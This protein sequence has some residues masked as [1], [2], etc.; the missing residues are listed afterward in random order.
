MSNQYP[1]NKDEFLEITGVGEVKYQ[2]YGERFIE[3]I[4]QY[5]SENNIAKGNRGEKEKKLPSN[6]HVNTDEELYLK[7]RELREEFAI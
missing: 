1:L 2:K 4:D 3:L 7:L 5:V 6:F